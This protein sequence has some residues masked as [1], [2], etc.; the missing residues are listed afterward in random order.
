MEQQHSTLYTYIKNQ[1]ILGAFT[2]ADLVKLVE[3]GRIT[4]DERLEIMSLK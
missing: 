1:Y 4:D 3:L 2:D